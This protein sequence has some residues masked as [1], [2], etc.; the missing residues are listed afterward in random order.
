MKK[1]SEITWMPG[2]AQIDGLKDSGVISGDHCA[3]LHLAKLVLT[4]EVAFAGER[5]NR[6]QFLHIHQQSA[7]QLI[8]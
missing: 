3:S 4:G 5:R 8:H 7:S 6:H 2:S 1:K